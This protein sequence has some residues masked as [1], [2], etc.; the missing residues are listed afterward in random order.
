MYIVSVRVANELE[1]TLNPVYPDT[2]IT[3]AFAGKTPLVGS[4]I[5]P[6]LFVIVAF[7]WET[8]FDVAAF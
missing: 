5:S 3:L 7:N 4:K 6:Q 1:L 8:M 2:K